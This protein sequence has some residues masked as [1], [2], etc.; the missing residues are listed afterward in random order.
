MDDPFKYLLHDACAH[1]LRD[2]LAP[3][4]GHV[5]LFQHVSS[6]EWTWWT[7]DVPLARNGKSRRVLLRDLGFDLELATRDFVEWLDDF[8]AG[9]MSLVQSEK[10]LPGDLHPSRF[11]TERTYL[12]VLANFGARL[13]FELPHANETA[14][15]TLFSQ[16]DI[17]R[18][19]QNGIAIIED[20]HTK[21]DIWPWSGG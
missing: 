7:A 18:I 17:E 20:P 5:R 3:D 15:V 16:S 19:R 13:V 11:R 9:G 6:P 8:E 10:R 1:H 4:A 2:L 21:Q 14:G 12:K